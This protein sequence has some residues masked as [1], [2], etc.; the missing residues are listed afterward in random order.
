MSFITRIP[1]TEMD[2]SATRAKT[3]PSAQRTETIFS[4]SNIMR[5]I[6]TR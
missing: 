5:M 2:P 4:L 6:R 3:D 1:R